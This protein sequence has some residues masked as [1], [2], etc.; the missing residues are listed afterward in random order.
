MKTIF[1]Y[2][3]LAFIAVAFFSCSESENLLPGEENV[4]TRASSPLLIASPTEVYFTDVSVETRVRDTVNVKV[5]GLPLL[6]MLT[7]FEVIIQGPDVLQF[8][9]TDP[10]LGLAEFLQALLGGGVDIPV[11]YRPYTHGSHEAELLI[12][13]SLLGLVAP[14]QITVPLHGNTTALPIPQLV[15]TIPVNGGTVNFDGPVE[16]SDKGEYHVDFIFDQ[17]IV[18]YNSNLIHLENITS[19]NT[20]GLQVING[21]TLRATIWEIPGVTVPNAVILEENAIISAQ[22]TDGD[23]ASGFVQGN[24]KIK[25]DYQAVGDI[26]GN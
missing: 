22:A 16:G 15:S 20:A 19:A 21:N 13:A 6:A 3:L 26:P 18:I 2:L 17:N 25:L 12:T 1:S 10:E 24:A 8:G 11:S 23:R 9:W 7:D 4:E 5:A 14:V